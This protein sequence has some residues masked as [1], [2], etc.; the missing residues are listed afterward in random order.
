MSAV[1]RAASPAE[2]RRSRPLM[3]KPHSPYNQQPV[4]CC[5]GPPKGFSASKTARPA[6]V[7]SWSRTRHRNLA[8]QSRLTTGVLLPGCRSMS[9]APTRSKRL[10][11]KR[12]TRRKK[13]FR[14][15]CS[16]CCSA[17]GTGRRSERRTRVRRRPA[18]VSSTKQ[19]SGTLLAAV[20]RRAHRLG[21]GL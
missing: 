16:P 6:K 7:R 1:L 14:T 18:V 4:W 9:A 13:R 15:R 21:P 11:R 3:H 19:L 5:L 17:C 8:F 10:P 20:P 2:N 12:W